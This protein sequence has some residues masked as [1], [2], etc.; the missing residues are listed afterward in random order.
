MRPHRL[1]GGSRIRNSRESRVD[2]LEQELHLNESK[3]KYEW[4]ANCY[5]DLIIQ[6]SIVPWGERL[7]ASQHTLFHRGRM[8]T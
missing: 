4:S 7:T 1:S 3:T 6:G 2:V 5:V 8:K